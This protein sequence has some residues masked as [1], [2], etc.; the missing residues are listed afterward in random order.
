[1]TMRT[2]PTVLRA[3]LVLVLAWGL[4]LAARS[5][6]QPDGRPVRAGTDTDQRLF[7]PEERDAFSFLILGDRTTGEPSG[8]AILEEGVRMA[9]RLD[10]DFTM[11]VGD[12][13][14]GYCEKAEWLEQARSYKNVIAK[15][16]RP[17]FPVVGNHDVYGKDRSPGGNVEIYKR[18]FGPLYYSFDYHWAHFV[19]LFSD[20]SL[21]FDDPARDQNLSREQFEWLRA[22]LAA[23]QATQVYVFLHHPRW[24]YAGTNWPEVHRLLAQDGRVRAVF[25]GHLHTL[26]DDGVKN[27]VHYHVLA[28]TGASVGPLRESAQIQEVAHVRVRRDGYSLSILPTGGVWAG[29]A[30]LGSE[31]DQMNAL[32]RGDWLEIEGAVEQALTGETRS[33]LVVRASNPTDRALSLALDLDAPEGWQMLAADAALHEQCA[34]LEPGGT[35]EVGVTVVAPAFARSAQM[36]SARATLAFALASGLVQPI[37]VERPLPLRLIGVKER[38]RAAARTNRALAFDGASAVRVP[39]AADLSAFTLECWVKG[40]SQPDWA[41]L[42]AKTQSSGFSLN[43]DSDRIAGNVRLVGRDEYVR[44]R[45]QRPLDDDEWTHVAFVWDGQHARLF[46]GGLLDGEAEAKGDLR[47]NALPLFVGADTNGKG[48]PEHPFVGAIDEVRVSRTARYVRGFAPQK[49]FE[50]DAD[51]L[52]LLHFDDDPPGV[53]LDASDAANH[54]WTQGAPRSIER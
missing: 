45:T 43:W 15:L 39:L 47:A 10:V 49:R 46:V 13:V 52:L 21:S 51:T 14:Q 27:G 37:Q 33:S 19:A 16:D 26:R 48:A 32:L 9:N 5:R 4:L 2:S 28:A 30:V 12:L 7:A 25:A 54:G 29:D 6:P 31:V 17:W 1:M 40:R 41:G 34:S 35:R 3:A 36:L 53:C 38:A 42:V 8:L 11:S 24:T 44:V 22:D 50:P 20:E 23:T 18:V